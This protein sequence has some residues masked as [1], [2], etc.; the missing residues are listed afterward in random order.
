M[1]VYA[2]ESYREQN[3]A[4]CK[5]TFA[6]VCIPEDRYRAFEIDLFRL[7]KHFW[8]VQE[9]SDLELKGRLLLSERAIELPKNREFI[10]QLIALL[11]EYNIV[12]LAV[13]QDGS[14]PLSTLKVDHLPQLY[15]AV[16]R[17]VDRYMV[18]KY[19]NDH[20]VLFFDGIDH[21]TNQKVA[22]SFTNYMFRHQAG[23][24]CQHILPVP[25]F[26]DSHRLRE[27]GTPGRL[28][29]RVPQHVIYVSES[30]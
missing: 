20:A 11:R 3:T 16:L 2:D 13:V 27:A 25:N 18:E 9:P 1:L 14:F 12:P 24:Q 15:R 8:K 19:P 26:S 30:R 6:A 10:R 4:N 29:R 28:L 17:R 23:I 21:Q 22:V 7:K 5:S